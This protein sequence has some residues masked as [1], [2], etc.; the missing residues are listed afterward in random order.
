MT[1]ETKEGVDREAYLANRLPTHEMRLDKLL[2]GG[3]V[4]S[5]PE[6]AGYLTPGDR[7]QVEVL[8]DGEVQSLS[9]TGRAIISADAELGLIVFY[10]A[11]TNASSKLKV[12][13][14]KALRFAKLGKVEIRRKA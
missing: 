13:G 12:E 10:E 5:E 9:G 7:M 14:A 3:R 4:T 8:F 6:S 2:A 1:F 11:E